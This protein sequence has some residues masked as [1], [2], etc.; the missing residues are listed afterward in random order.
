MDA[1]QEDPAVRLRESHAPHLPEYVLGQ[2]HALRG[3]LA[4]RAIGE[5]VDGYP[6]DP[7]QLDE[8]ADAPGRTC[9]GP[10][11]C[12]RL[13]PST[14]AIPAWLHPWIRMTAA[15]RSWNVIAL[16]SLPG[17]LGASERDLFGVGGRRGSP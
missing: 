11:D 2:R 14:S 6:E 15:S 17:R 16:A 1:V 9:R 5:I 12:L 10:G 13:T 7:P 8:V 3:D 4:Q